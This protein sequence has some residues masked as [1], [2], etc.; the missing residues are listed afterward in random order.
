M[1]PDP[2]FD[3]EIA[4]ESDSDSG[5]DLEPPPSPD[6]LPLEPSS[7]TSTPRLKHSIGARIQA[8]YFLELNIPHFEI[9]AKT[10]ISKA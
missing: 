7:E 5:A 9:T 4:F 3:F 10:E 2:A 8:V 1:D 6:L